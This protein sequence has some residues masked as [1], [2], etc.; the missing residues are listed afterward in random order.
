[1]KRITQATENRIKAMK[2]SGNKYAEELDYILNNVIKGSAGCVGASIAEMKSWG[3]ELDSAGQY[4]A[5]ITNTTRGMSILY[6]DY[7]HTVDCLDLHYI[8]LYDFNALVR[9]AAQA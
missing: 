2:Q 6:P 3:I 7:I 8:N 4:R 9:A 5:I 1:M